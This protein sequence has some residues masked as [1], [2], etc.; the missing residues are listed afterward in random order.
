MSAANWFVSNIDSR[1]S[2]EALRDLGP[3]ATL[4]IV[5]LNSKY[6]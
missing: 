1:T 3:A 6:V 4:F 2:V 5:I